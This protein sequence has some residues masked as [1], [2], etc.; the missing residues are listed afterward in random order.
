LTFT[1]AIKNSVRGARFTVILVI[2]VGGTRHSWCWG[3]VT[4]IENITNDFLRFRVAWVED[5]TND[6]LFFCG[7][8]FNT[9]A[10]NIISN[11]YW[12]GTLIHDLEL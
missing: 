5:I 6:F 4:G 3:S 1:W 7:F 11:T 10:E 12:L 8:V 9:I 2:Q